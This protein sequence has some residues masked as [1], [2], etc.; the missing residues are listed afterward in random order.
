MGINFWIRSLT[1]VK[2]VESNSLQ[3]FDFLVVIIAHIGMYKT[4]FVYRGEL[5][6]VS[7]L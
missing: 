5:K 1:N 6:C 4:T 7:M 3:P 2:G